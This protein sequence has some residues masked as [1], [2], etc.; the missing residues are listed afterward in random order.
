[1]SDKQHLDLCPLDL[2]P[3]CGFDLDLGPTEDS[4]KR[5]SHKIAVVTNDQVQY[6]I[7]PWCRNE[8]DPVPDMSGF[9]T[10]NME[11]KNP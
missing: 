9:R 10:C 11:I 8:V 1:M 2:C 5:Y 7:C 3:H 4:G 6:F